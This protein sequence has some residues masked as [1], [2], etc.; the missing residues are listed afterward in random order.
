MLPVEWSGEWPSILTGTQK[1]PYVVRRPA[2]SSAAPVVNAGNFVLR[3][4]FD[5]TTLAPYWEMMRTPREQLVRPHVDARLADRS[6]RGVTRYPAAA[7]R[8]GS[9]AGSSI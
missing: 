9:D 8:R 1:V 2:G 4:E 3:D 7:S 5:D 6:A